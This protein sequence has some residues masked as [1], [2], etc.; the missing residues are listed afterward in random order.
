MN[1][2]TAIVPY[3][4]PTTVLLIDDDSNFLANFSL[5][6]DEM[7][8]FRLFDAP[9]PALR[10]IE[11]ASGYAKAHGQWLHTQREAVG[12]PLRDH[13]LR[14]D[15]AAIEEESTNPDRFREISVVV[16]DYA[17]PEMDGL[18]FCRQITN[19]NIKKVLI[20]GVGDAK[21]A[22]TAFN[23]GIIDRFI[24]KGDRDA[25]TQVNAAVCE[26][27]EHYFRDVSRLVL[28]S[29]EGEVPHFLSDPVFNVYFRQLCAD[30][31][32][33]E[34]YF[35][36]E[37][38]GLLLLTAEGAIFRFVILSD[39][40]MDTHWEIA[41]DQEAPGEMLSALQ[42]R[43]KVPYFWKS[44]GYYRTGAEW[45]PHL[46]PA[47]RLDAAQS[48]YVALIENPPAY[49]EMGWQISSYRS[50]LDNFDAEPALPAD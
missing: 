40:Q 15:L 27:Q 7:I 8:A 13:C 24:L 46:F 50:Y 34:H 28:Q 48:Y 38:D 4:F 29:L 6:L 37:P 25:A 12:W 42:S 21:L 17:M 30:R 49:R 1:D 41:R 43:E 44:G 39:E 9:G 14:L 47:H 31:G 5:E 16:V 11:E 20:T 23:E 33:V 19:R 22:V 10:H 45:E 36:A 18:T 35:V 3:R 2:C 32:I 26:L